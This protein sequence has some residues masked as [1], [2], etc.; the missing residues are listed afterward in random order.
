MCD[1]HLIELCNRY[2]SGHTVM[3]HL[4]GATFVMENCEKVTVLFFSKIH[5]GNGG[6]GKRKDPLLCV[7]MNIIQSLHKCEDA[8]IAIA[9]NEL[10]TSMFGKELSMCCGC[11]KALN[12]SSCQGL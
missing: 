11:S 6:D 12:G 2:L 10:T 7:E 5:G 8:N 1:V 4:E 9:T 3:S